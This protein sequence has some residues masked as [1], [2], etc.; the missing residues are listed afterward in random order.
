[1]LEKEKIQEYTLL[2]ANA[3]ELVDVYNRNHIRTGLTIA[4]SEV[5]PKGDF[6]LVVHLCLFDRGGRMLLQ[7]RSPEKDRYPDMWDVSAGGF[8]RS[9]EE[10]LEAVLREAEEELGIN[11]SESETFYLT[12]E[13]FSYVLDDFF[14]AVA[15]A[16]KMHFRLQ[17]E[18]VTKVK[19]ATK[20]EV[21]A[22]RAGGTLVDYA[23]DLL[24]RLFERADY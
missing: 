7:R 15:D 3:M 4:R 10:P 23:H 17:T 22:M 16:D 24:E 2:E 1:M 21:L 6:L 5:P 18:E 14:G 11:L 8:V 19:W 9:G 12:T 20:E 13:L